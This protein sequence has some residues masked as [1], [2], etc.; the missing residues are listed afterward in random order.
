M[1]NS[2]TARCTMCHLI[3]DRPLVSIMGE[4]V[5]VPCREFYRL[6]MGPR[7]YRDVKEDTRR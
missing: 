6:T 2:A 7:R 4:L 3:P 5:C 1:Q